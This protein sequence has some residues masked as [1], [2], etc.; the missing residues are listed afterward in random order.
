MYDKLHCKYMIN[1][2]VIEA[3][4]IKI[5]P[6]EFGKI[7]QREIISKFLVIK[8]LNDQGCK[9]YSSLKLECKFHRQ[10]LCSSTLCLFP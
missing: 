1:L 10:G 9:S 8:V 3:S 2:T 6:L 4:V 5:F 7:I